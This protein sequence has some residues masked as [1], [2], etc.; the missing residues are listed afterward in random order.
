MKK[1]VFEF[2]KQVENLSKELLENN[3]YEL[4]KDLNNA[5]NSGLGMGSEIIGT[6]RNSIKNYKGPKITQKELLM[7]IKKIY[8]FTN[9]YFKF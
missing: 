5:L 9:Y 7:K 4:A 3:Y 1:D 6:I 2:Y 8:K